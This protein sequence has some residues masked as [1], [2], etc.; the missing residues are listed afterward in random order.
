MVKKNLF[1]FLFLFILTVSLVSAN[2]YAGDEEVLYSGSCNELNVKISY[3]IPLIE[4]EFS[5]YPNCIK[6]LESENSL[7]YVCNCT[8]NYELLFKTLINADNTYYFNISEYNLIDDE[9]DNKFVFNNTNEVNQ[10]NIIQLPNNLSVNIVVE[11]NQTFQYIKTSNN[12]IIIPEQNVTFD[13]YSING[14]SLEIKA[15]SSG[16][17]SFIIYTETK[18]INVLLNGNGIAY[19]YNSTTKIL[20]FV[21]HFST[22][23]ISVVYNI[24]TVVSSNSGSSPSR[25]GFFSGGDAIIEPN[26][27]NITDDN[28]TEVLDPMQICD[29]NVHSKSSK[30][31]FVIVI[32]MIII[33]LIMGIYLYKNRDKNGN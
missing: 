21:A 6:Q 16:N 32:T 10:T 22:S 24:P 20:T 28:D 1:S 4:N 23:S 27:V 3:D 5:L 26:P 31:T 19:D 33:S 17:K 25:H 7:T 8:E 13:S 9:I 12:V 15:T 30:V 11:P 29:S 2:Y 14:N 18:P